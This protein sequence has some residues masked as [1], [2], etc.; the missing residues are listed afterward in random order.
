MRDKKPK[1]KD[2]FRLGL[3][4]GLWEVL[5]EVLYEVFQAFLFYN[6]L[7]LSSL[8]KTTGGLGKKMKIHNSQFSFHNYAIPS[9][10]H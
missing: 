3:T 9:L 6:S 1:I 10:L 5:G 4:G 8:G 7:I 2:A